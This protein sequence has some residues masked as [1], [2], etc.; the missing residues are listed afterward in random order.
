MSMQRFATPFLASI[1][2]FLN[3]L[4]AGAVQD[5]PPTV[6]DEPLF[7][8]KDPKCVKDWSPI[9]LPGVEKEAPSPRFEIVPPGNGSKEN[10]FKITFAG[11]DWPAIATSKIPV[12]GNWKQFQTLK[13]DLTAERPCVAYFRICQ[14]KPD[15][16]P[17]QPCWEKTLMLQPGRN[18]V[19]LA[20]R[21]GLGSSIIDPKKGDIT[22]FAIGMFQPD[23]DQALLVSNVRLSADWPPPQATGWFSPYNHDGYSTAVARECQRTGALPKFKV[24]GTD[25]E[26]ADLRELAKKLEDKWVKPEPKTIEQVE[27]EFK[28]EFA[29]LKQAHP[30]A[31]MAIL[32]DGETGWN[33]AMPDKA[34]AGW[35]MHYQNSHGPDGPNLGREVS[36][37]LHDTVESFMR[38]RGVLLRADLTCIPKDAMILAA[39]F[40]ATRVPPKD[41]KMME[42]ANLWV[43]EPCNRDWDPAAA[44]CYLYA[45]GKYWKAVNGLY[46]GEDPDHWPVFVM[47]GPAGGGLVSAW[48]FSEAFKFWQQPDHPNHGFFLHC[49]NDY[50]RLYTHL[51]KEIKLRPAIMVV[52]EPKS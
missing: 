39:K 43:A 48:D 26:V 27:A 31:V 37:P 32:R 41:P 25:M 12:A 13:A 23:K 5:K 11:G 35:K 45:P 17:K 4:L 14:G 1:C 6:P 42:K 10:A 16:Q 44:N 24:L 51:A 38:H 29:K 2:L 33:P 49:Q 40:V 9:K 18:E 30:K 50:M 8:F 28:A 3:A 22:S 15:D 47:H 7:D 34:Y 52:Y 46:Y 20:I 21:H 36:Q 19:A